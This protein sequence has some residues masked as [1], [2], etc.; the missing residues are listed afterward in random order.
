MEAA[1]ALFLPVS[2]YR[3]STTINRLESYGTYWSSSY[4]C[5]NAGR[6]SQL[7]FSLSSKG[8]KTPPPSITGS[9]HNIGRSVRLV[10]E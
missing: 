3:T 5:D 1:G 7:S 10:C 4:D 6:A 8:D 9:D 2:G